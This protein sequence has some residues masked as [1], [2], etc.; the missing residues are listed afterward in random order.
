MVALLACG[1]QVAVELDALEGPVEL[2]A[3]GRVGLGAQAME[4]NAIAV[5]QVVEVGE[6]LEVQQFQH[7]CR[8]SRFTGGDG[9][10]QA[11]VRVQ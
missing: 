10:Q 5:R 2:G 7:A 8:L 3:R 9:S 4:A 1:A 11:D 6:V